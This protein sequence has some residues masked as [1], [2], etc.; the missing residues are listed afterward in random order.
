MKK[1][2]SNAGFSLIFLTCCFL[3]PAHAQTNNYI[4]TTGVKTSNYPRVNAV[5]WYEVDP[6]WPQRP[7]DITWGQVPGIA[8][9]KQDNVW[10]YT[11]TNPA[12]QVYGPD[13]RFIRSWH[14]NNTNAAP[15]GLKID[16]EGNIWLVDV[17][18]QTVTKR[19]PDGKVLLTL[20]T[21]GVS[22]CDASHFFKPTDVTVAF[23]G[24]IFITDGYGNA[25]VV[26]YDKEG[27]FINS[28]GRLG[29]EPGCFSI[30]HAVV[31]D[32]RGRVY[33]ADRN[34]ARIQVFD[35]KGQLLDVWSNIM[36]PWGLWISPKDEIWACGSSPMIWKFDP[37][38]PT[39]PLGCPPKDQVFMRFNTDG[40]L[41]QLWAV[42]KAEDGQ[43]KPGSLNWL[44]GIA[45]DSK[46]N[47]FCTDITGRRVQKFVRKTD[48]QASSC[49]R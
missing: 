48:P 14:V 21:E 3:Q 6:T 18:L 22:G 16:T 17:R 43:E 40:K 24:D 2:K 49:A 12:V 39:A 41:L 5:T 27:H 47:I 10:I 42:P 26:H 25:R 28:W 30:P 35:F 31:C 29:S 1:I 15:H 34:N 13:G 7:S 36:V 46:A 33:I 45:L 19:S 8:I 38:Y 37:K 23:N 9:D 4:A 11:R 44:H 20:G 32:S